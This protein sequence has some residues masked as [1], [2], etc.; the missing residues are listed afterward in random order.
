MK[1]HEMFEKWV[2]EQALGSHALKISCL[3]RFEPY[4]IKISKNF[5]KEKIKC[6]N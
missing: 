2:Y 4:K 3:W 1:K 5:R 6:K